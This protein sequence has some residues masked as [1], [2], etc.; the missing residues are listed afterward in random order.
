MEGCG[1]IRAAFAVVDADCRQNTIDSGSD[2]DDGDDGD[3]GSGSD[4]GGN[5]GDG[6]AGDGDGGGGAVASSACN[7]REPN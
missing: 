6:G 7:T 4:G 3:D 2:D 5:D 1:R